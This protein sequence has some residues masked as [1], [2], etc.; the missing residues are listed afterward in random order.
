MHP[1]KIRRL[2]SALGSLQVIIGLGAVAGGLGLAL[3]PSGA[4]VGLP[5]EMLKNTPFSSFLIPGIVLLTVIGMGSLLGGAAS[6]TRRRYAGEIALGSRCRQI[7]PR[8]RRFDCLSTRDTGDQDREQIPNGMT[9]KQSSEPREAVGHPMGSTSSSPG[10]IRSDSMM[11][12]GA[13]TGNPRILSCV[14]DVHLIVGLFRD[15]K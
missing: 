13:S 1:R 6:F 15:P 3:D 11:R 12:V 14:S 4:S 7:R 9:Q 8:R 2:A 5:L 10:T